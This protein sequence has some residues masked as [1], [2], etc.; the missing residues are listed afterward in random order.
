MINTNE[1]GIQLALFKATVEQSNMLTGTTKQN[2]KMIFNQWQKLG[3]KILKVMENNS[4][5]DELEEVTGVIENAIN[6]LRII[7]Q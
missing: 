1:W 2:T 3:F 7:N 6:K 5:L 4:N